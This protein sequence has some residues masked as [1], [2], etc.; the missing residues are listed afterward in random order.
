[1]SCL[2]RRLLRYAAVPVVV[3]VTLPLSV[4]AFAADLTVTD[5]RGDMWVIREGSTTA[6]Q[7]PRASIG[8]FVRTTFRHT[9]RRVAVR[10]K[11]VEL[12]REGRRFRMW[13]DLRDQAG[14]RVFAL[15]ETT[16]RDR[17]GRTRMFTGSGRDIAC[18]ISHR[19]DYAQNTVRVS[20]PRRCL[21]NP[22]TLQFRTM[23]EFSRQNLRFARVDNPSNQRA[24][25][26]AWSRPLR[27]S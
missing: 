26:R 23:S 22:R 25:S 3:L 14:R 7:A 27:A 19:V 9:D 10:S 18:N 17:N 24:A 20:F 16:R 12:A 4:P 6:A 8:D 5:G 11:F 2:V 13:V 1:M 21:N 15:V